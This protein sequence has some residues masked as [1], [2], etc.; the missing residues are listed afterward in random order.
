MALRLSLNLQEAEHRYTTRESEELRKLLEG[1]GIFQ[2]TNLYRAVTSSERIRKLRQYGTDHPDQDTL[3]LY[4]HEE[5]FSLEGEE[6]EFFWDFLSNDPSVIAVFDG[7]RLSPVP[8]DPYTFCFINPKKRREAL[9][10]VIDV[11]WE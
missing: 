1:A 2:E 3:M 4:T 11:R 6:H 7:N 9:R 8:N 10:A 5:I